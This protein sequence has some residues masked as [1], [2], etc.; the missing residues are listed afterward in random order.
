MHLL[1]QTG[2]VRLP[3]KVLNEN[4]KNMQVCCVEYSGDGDGLVR[5]P[6]QV[7]LRPP[8]LVNGEG[9]KVAE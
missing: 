9:L 3:I 7:C 6:M 1:E 8:M 5:E 2:A 4:M